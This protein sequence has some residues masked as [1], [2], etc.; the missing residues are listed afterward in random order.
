[1]EKDFETENAVILGVSKDSQGSHKRFIEKKELT[2]KLL[3][4]GQAENVLSELESFK[5]NK[6]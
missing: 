4:D 3:S 2:I 6:I 5:E 1:M